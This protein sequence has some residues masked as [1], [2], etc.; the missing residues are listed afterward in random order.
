MS[1]FFVFGCW[2]LPKKLAVAPKYCFTQ[3]GSYV[4]DLS[5]TFN[6]KQP[7][8]ILCGLVTTYTD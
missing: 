3:L 2:L 4:Y 8:L 7:T 6:L 1:Y 5:A